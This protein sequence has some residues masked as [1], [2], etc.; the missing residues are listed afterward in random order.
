MRP[1]RGEWLRRLLHVGFGTA[2]LL[3]RWLDGWQAAGLAL[4]AFLFNWQVLPRVGGRRL[5]RDPDL[6]RGYAVGI[7]AYPLALL[8][9]VVA[10]HDRLWM[11]AAGWG[12]L[13]VGDGMASLVGQTLGGP[14]LPW[15]RGKTWVGSAAFVVFGT[16]A[17]GL[18]V[19][20]TR[21]L[22]LAVGAAHWPGT[23]RLSAALALACA[24]VESLPVALDDNITVPLAVVL[25]LP[26]L[27]ALGL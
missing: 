26:L 3:L 9:L 22:P 4:A 17:A 2:A 5:W 24:A 10:F 6:A 25:L 13:A 8:A 23:L 16:A 14:R 15:N 12:I 27:A 1:S 7:L 21:R 19:G 20:W 18:L 11:A